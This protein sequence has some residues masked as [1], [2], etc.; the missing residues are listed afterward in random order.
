[1]KR[2]KRPIEINSKNVWTALWNGRP[3]RSGARRPSLG[4]PLTGNPLADSVEAA[5]SAR[6]EAGTYWP[7]EEISS[8]A[9]EWLWD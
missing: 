7:I 2:P 4:R 5:R 9:L 1:M 8:A 6:N 3:P